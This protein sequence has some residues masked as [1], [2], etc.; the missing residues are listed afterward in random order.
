MTEERRITSTA[1][2][3]VR[4]AAT[5][6]SVRD[7]RATGQTLV[8]GARE[9]RRALEAGVQV[10][11]AF[12]CEP[13]LAGA[14]AAVV[15]ERLRTAR[16]P[17]SSVSEP[18]FDKLAFG[19]RSEGI[20]LVVAWAPLRLEDLRLPD[21]PLVLVLESVEKPGNLGA[22]LRSADGAGVDAV[23]AAAPRT[24]LA[25]PNVIR[26]SAG[27]VFSV[28]VASAPSETV[29]AWLLA[30]GI[31]VVAAHVDAEHS[32]TNAD[33][34]GPVAVVLGAEDVGLSEVW[35]GDGIG[36]IRL[37]M[38]G[39]AD[40]LNVS[41]TAAILAYEARRQRDLLAPPSTTQLE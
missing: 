39:V 20:V 7:R 15:L 4:A 6:R 33:L 19:D 26:A 37:P 36:S 5:L 25:N 21:P 1:N 30:E 41:V 14:D 24:D 29:L 32:Y 3:R 18:V 13:L 22:A 23:I 8:D 10:R 35:R 31:R 28:P 2:P 38:L 16:V 17:V 11:E 27:T 12:V 34:T 40:S 9:A